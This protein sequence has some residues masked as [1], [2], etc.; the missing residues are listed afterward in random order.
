LPD[1]RE[2]IHRPA[3]DDLPGFDIGGLTA[4]R[5]H[6]YK[7]V[8]VQKRLDTDLVTFL[9]SKCHELLLL[10]SGG[11]T[12]I[13]ALPASSE[14]DAVDVTIPAQAQPLRLCLI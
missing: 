12:P 4:C 14:R 3:A 5:I 9:F 11:G 13:A 6:R 10:L 1:V 7:G 2:A 8:E